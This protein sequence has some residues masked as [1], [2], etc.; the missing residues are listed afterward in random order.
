[1]TDATPER[2]ATTKAERVAA[3]AVRLIEDWKAQRE[4]FKK[5]REA[6]RIESNYSLKLQQHQPQSTD[7][8]AAKPLRVVTL[9]LYD[10]IRYSSA[11]VRKADIYLSVRPAGG[12]ST[13]A[14]DIEN[15]QAAEVAQAALTD[16]ITSIEKGY[17]RVR[18]R[19]IR[20]SIA[21]RQGAAKLEVVPGGPHGVE[22][23][24]REV[25]PGNLTWDPRF[26]HFND[27][28]CPSLWERFR[29]PLAA[30]RANKDW[31]NTDKLT[32][33]DG[34]KAYPEIAGPTVDMAAWELHHGQVTLAVGWLKEEVEVAEE[35]KAPFRLDPRNWFMACSKCGYTEHDMSHHAGYD[36]SQLPEQLPCPN[37]PPTVEGLPGAM[38]DRIEVEPDF[39]FQPKRSQRL[40][41]VI[42]APCSPG[43]GFLRD[44]EWP[45]GLT[46]FPYMMH[47]SDPFPLEPSGNSQ[48]SLNMD[49]QSLKNESVRAG[50]EQMDRNRDLLLVKEDALWDANHEP[51]EYGSGD[52]VAYVS[53]YESLRGIQHF[54][55]SGLNPA[56]GMWMDRMDGELGRF[57]GTGQF[58]I[59]AQSM[60]GTPVG[61][62]AR[63]Q[64]SGDVPLDEQISIL[65]EDEE[66]FFNR[67]L[68]MY[69]AYADTDRWVEVDGINGA[70]AMR[71]F[72][73]TKMPP[74]R[75]R[76]HAQADMNAVDAQGIERLVSL[77]GKPASVV[78][79]AGK[80][81][82]LPHNV[83]EDLIRETALPAPPSGTGGLPQQPGAVPMPAGVQ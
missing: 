83:I 57:R 13:E 56:F 74:L 64:E 24:P 58:N 39:E 69:V 10:N 37:C 30:A 49:L 71:L 42:L 9:D 20:H 35:P 75:L 29:V 28:G 66:Q 78:R 63:S 67:W 68:E 11:V 76:L 1:V 47:V 41:R 59:N 77:A 51:F 79:Y 54:Q 53:D 3:E 6:M 55:G 43:A 31:K 52:F 4:A 62:I 16:E 38:M 48:T 17:P 23:V 27:Y 7:P 80:R 26:V 45:N 21:A 65:R 14:Q 19:V 46:N 5:V 44:G 32:P 73:G 33:D 34:E 50:F 22:I 81:A 8:K 12:A 25:D 60:K 40:R 15:E 2:A 36:G 70:R 61:T 72:N 18:R 82:N